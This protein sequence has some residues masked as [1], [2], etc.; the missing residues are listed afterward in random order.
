MAPPELV[1]G[2][3]PYVLY[4]FGGCIAN[5]VVSVIPLVVMIA[6]WR[7]TYWH[8]MVVLWAFIGLFYVITNGIPMKLQGMP[9][10]G[11]NALS[12]GKDSEALKAFW[13]QMKINEQIALGKR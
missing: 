7:P 2:K 5:L 13:L 1:D 8:F 3:I 4:N 11:H 6:C 12:L 9:N 10:D